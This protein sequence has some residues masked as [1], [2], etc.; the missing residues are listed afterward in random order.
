MNLPSPLRRRSLFVLLSLAVV[1][2]FVLAASQAAEAAKPGAKTEV[3]DDSIFKYLTVFT[4]VLGLVRNAYVEPTEPELLMTSA[5]E[6]TVDALDPF[7]A[8]VPALL[9]MVAS[10]RATPAMHQ[11]QMQ[12]RASNAA[13]H[14]AIMQSLA[15]NAAI[16]RSNH[17]SNMAN[18]HTLA[19]S[20]QAHMANLHQAADARNASWQAEQAA[21]DGAHAA[22]MQAPDDGHRRFLN[23]IAEERTVVDAE[24]N[25][26][27][28]Q[29]G[30]DRYFRRRSDGTWIGTKD[31]RDL[32]GL[33]GVNPD[34][35]DEAQVV[36]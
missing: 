28:V 27:Q 11:R 24:G 1:M 36:V 10:Q 30:F 31:Q 14:Q 3:E 18:L 6:G 16:L 35:F 21:R 19:A 5:L 32:R 33:P 4:E 20:H 8:F 15:T 34:E 17:Q 22:R 2:P 29:D 12:E 13:R 26:H 7:A 23:L 9:E 25:R